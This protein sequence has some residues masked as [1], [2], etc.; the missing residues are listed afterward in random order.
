MN[1]NPWKKLELQIRFLGKKQVV[2]IMYPNPFIEKGFVYKIKKKKI[3]PLQKGFMIWIFDFFCVTNLSSKRVLKNHY[4]KKINHMEGC[5][6]LLLQSIPIRKKKKIDK[7]WR[8]SIQEMKNFRGS[9][10]NDSY[11]ER[12]SL[13]F[14]FESQI[15]QQNVI[16]ITNLKLLNSNPWIR[17]LLGLAYEFEGELSPWYSISKVSFLFSIIV[18]LEKWLS[19]TITTGKL[20][21]AWPKFHEETLYLD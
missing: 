9:E 5:R 10:E 11:L 6:N 4:L 7:C 12:K 1:S 14:W 8:F 20:V 16:Q 18:Q 2:R 21:F 19:K 3:L 15:I 17:M 13:F